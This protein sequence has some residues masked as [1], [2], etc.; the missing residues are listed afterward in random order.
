ME[1]AIVK[2]Q[3]LKILP[4]TMN[5]IN[6][7]ANQYFDIRKN[8]LNKILEKKKYLYSTYHVS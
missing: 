1:F 6:D 5:Y 8:S 2:E 3:W 7:K 4:K